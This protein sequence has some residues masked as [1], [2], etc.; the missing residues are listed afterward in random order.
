MPV[1]PIRERILQDCEEAL[2]LIDGS[3][4]YHCALKAVRRG[5]AT[6]EDIL[7]A[8]LDDGPE[9][10]SRVPNAKLTRKFT[11]TVEVYVQDEQGDLSSLGNR[12]LGDLERALTTDPTRG[13]L[14]VNTVM[15]SNEILA[16]EAPGTLTQVRAQ[17]LITYRTQVARPQSSLPATWEYEQGIPNIPG[18]VCP[19]ITLACADAVLPYVIRQVSPSSGGVVNDI[20]Q[21]GV[22]MDGGG[23]QVVAGQPTIYQQ[24]ERSYWTGS[25]LFSEWWIGTIDQ[26]GVARRHLQ[27]TADQTNHTYDW[28]T[29]NVSN[30]IVDGA[31][32]KL[33]IA[34]T[35]TNGAALIMIGAGEHVWQLNFGSAVG[36]GQGLTF[37]QAT[38][39]TPVLA[40]NDDGVAVPG[41]LYTAGLL[42]LASQV[43]GAGAQTGTLTNAPVAGPPAFWAPIEVNGVTRHV[44]VW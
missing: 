14:A 41:Y 2:W 38:D 23:G 19:V 25:Q 33:Q 42:R 27:L 7:T 11:V 35:T 17:F 6:P 30:F 24:F 12:M 43:D 36:Y 44:P 15:T 5:K 21:I 4:L 29:V 13:A 22:N 18:L 16:D 20:L 37:Y 31:S 10:V 8:C 28:N 3:G 34:S 40:L 39:G 9:E 32:P 1:D 26:T